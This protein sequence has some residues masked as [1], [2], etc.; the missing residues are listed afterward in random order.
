MKTIFSIVLVSLITFTSFA[1]TAE[2]PASDK[3]SKLI[4]M[5]NNADKSDWV[6]LNKAA[7]YN[8]NWNAD[9]ELAKQWIEASI[10]INDNAEAYELLGDY[11]L[12]KGDLE[13]AY[14]NYYTALEK[15]MFSLRKSDFER[16]QRKNLVFGR[17]LK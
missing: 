9:I 17:S 15:G 13:K 14:E 10:A 5:V 1:K 3:M 8:I 2:G 6:T 7:S 16:I 11:H 4:K 12:R